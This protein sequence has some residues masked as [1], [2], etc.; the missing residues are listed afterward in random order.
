MAQS[1]GQTARTGL[2]GLGRAAKAVTSATTAPGRA[3]L[4]ALR[5]LPKATQGFS[6]SPQAGQSFG[7]AA[8]KTVGGAGIPVLSPIANAA[9][10]VSAAQPTAPRL[11]TA[12]QNAQ[13]SRL[14]PS[15]DK[16]TSLS[17]TPTSVPA[18]TL[19]SASATAPAITTASPTS[20]READARQYLQ[21]ESAASLAM[22][23][24]NLVQ[25]MRGDTPATSAASTDTTM[26]AA[27][28]PKPQ[29]A[30]ASPSRGTSVLD[31][32]RSKVGSLSAPS[33][34]EAALQDE[35]A[36]FRGDAQMGIAGLEG[37][38]RGIPLS[39]VRGQQAQL[40]E[41]ASLQE[42]T[43]LDR[44][45]AA[46][47]QR[48]A[49]LTAAQTEL[50]YATQDQERQDRLAAQ[51]QAR[52]DSYRQEVGNSIIQYNPETGTYDTLYTAPT[53][54]A[55]QPA[56]VQEYEY[57][58]GNG[59]TGSFLDYQAAKAAASG[60][61]SSSSSGAFTLGDTRYNADGSVL[62]DGSQS[63]TSAGLSDLGSQALSLVGELINDPGRA[64]ATGTARIF[65]SLPG[66][67]AYDYRAKLERLQSLLSLD[68]IKYLKGTG[69][70]SDK[71]SA[72]LQSA[73][74]ALK[75]GMSEGAFLQELQR[76][77]TDLSAAS[78]GTSQG[79]T[80]PQI[81]QYQN[82]LQQGQ[83]TQQEYDELS[84]GFTSAGSTALNSSAIKAVAQN[85]PVGS[86][87]YQCGR[88]V[89]R[90]TGLKMG[91]SYASKMAYVN[92]ALGKTEPVKPGDVFVMEYDKSG[93]TGLVDD[94][95]WISKSDGTFDIP[96]IDSNFGLDEKVQRHYINSSRMSGF[97]RA[98]VTSQ[99]VSLS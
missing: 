5:G 57:A 33:A 60:S 97:A 85:Y 89:N 22:G 91:D 9:S 34:S 16:T 51:E 27:I 46:S 20:S 87:G 73:S 99:R 58:K 77:Q 61:S 41:Q 30:P 78:Q 7:T 90:L 55:E 2:K 10:A 72:I 37:Q 81:Q 79:S 47:A 45:S 49:A 43:L 28:M 31:Q 83:I 12:A 24:K 54:A 44:I 88:F 14:R 35:L 42:Q 71:E 11:S 75:P 69:A 26:N 82:L 52:Q 17:G 98:P 96:V 95:K 23:S 32:L 62:V 64:G 19:T 84:Q 59:Y 18:S 93:H 1:Y 29:A 56:T 74:A 63:T 3:V 92:P 50:G 86:R 67:P 65:A 21:D 94:G 40:G 70:I 4:S 68:S 8:L 13:L 53:G 66:T 15:A 36:Q 6:T 39:L 48:Q 25:A 76:I 38:G 80:N